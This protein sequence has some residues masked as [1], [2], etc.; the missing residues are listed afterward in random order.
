[1]CRIKKLLGFLSNMAI[2]LLGVKIELIPSEHLLSTGHWLGL[3]G[4]G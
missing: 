4:Y 1:M 2:E 3:M